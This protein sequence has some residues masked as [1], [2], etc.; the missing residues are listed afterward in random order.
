MA[1]LSI[2]LL[3]KNSERTVKWALQSLLIQYIPEGLEFELIVVD[4]YSRDSTLDIVENYCRKLQSKLPANFAG[5]RVYRERV[6]VGFARNI[7]LRRAHGDW[8]LWLDSDTIL[9]HDYISSFLKKVLIG[10]LPNN[11][12]V[13]YPRKVLPILKGFRSKVMFCQSHIGVSDCSRKSA[14]RLPYTAMQGTFTLRQALLDVGGFDNMLVAAED[15][16]IH[17]KLLARGYVRESFNGVLY[18]IPRNTFR[19]FFV[20]A[21]VWNYGLII[22]L[23]RNPFSAKKLRRKLIWGWLPDRWRGNIICRVY[24]EP[25][26]NY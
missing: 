16:D 13:L 7:A 5:C 3:T 17:M 22:A 1:F 24:P 11:V 8:I 2:A 26:L 14:P 19:E 12:A 6:G 25:S 15:V 21:M 9:S 20:Q 23:R 4:G 18:V 10:K